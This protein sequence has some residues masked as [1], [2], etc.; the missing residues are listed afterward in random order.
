MVNVSPPSLDV[1]AAYAFIARLKK[2]KG[3]ASGLRIN[4]QSDDGGEWSELSFSDDLALDA[5]RI[6]RTVECLRG[7]VADGEVSIEASRVR[8]RTGQHFL[9]HVSEARA[10]YKRDDVEP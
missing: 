3:V 4:V 10:E 1:S 2:H 8:Y 7:L 6:E 5:E 9:D